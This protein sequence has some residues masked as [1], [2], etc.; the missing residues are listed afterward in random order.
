M[1]VTGVQASLKWGYYEA[2][3]LSTWTVTKI[4]DGPGWSL[5]ATVRTKKESWVSQHPLVFV[6][7]HAGGAWRFPVTA[8][9]I[10]DA[11]LTATLGP[12]E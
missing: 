11:S 2:A 4:A 8:L 6:A 12:K 10:T 5:S 9:Q 1:T 3:T 7:P